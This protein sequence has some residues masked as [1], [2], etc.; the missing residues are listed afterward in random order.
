MSS[1]FFRQ[2]K[3]R[4]SDNFSYLVGDNESGFAAVVDPPFNPKVILDMVAENDFKLIYI[5]VTHGHPDH[6]GG[7]ERLRSATGAK[8]VA[9]ERSDI[10][11]DLL[12]KDQ[13]L[14]RLGR[15][16]IKVIY[17]PGHSPDG[18]CLLVDDR[19]LMTGD[20]LF[21]GE[22]GRTDLQGGDSKKLYDSLFNKLMKLDDSVE[23]YPG[24]DY[25]AKPHST[26]GFERKNNYTLKPRSEEEFIKFMAT[27]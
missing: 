3:L 14:I 13:E 8:V 10:K 24:H 17:T 5:M 16:G 26:I 21:V 4:D 2:V 9:H 18:I 22:C 1:L 11:K 6:T 12:V 27:P 25:G 23:V 20:T 19:I 15:V 7:I